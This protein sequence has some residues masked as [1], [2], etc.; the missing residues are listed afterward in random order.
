M[1]A[2]TRML[3]AARLGAIVLAFL[4]AG[5][6]SAAVSVSPS[7]LFIPE[8]QQ[9]VVTITYRFTGLVS[10]L[11]GAYSGPLSSPVGEF[12]TGRGILLSVPTTV[13]A[14]IQGGA[15]VVTETLTLPA[16]LLDAVRRQG[17]VS[18][19]YDRTFTDTPSNPFIVNTASTAVNIGSEASASFAIKRIELYFDNR[20]G[21]ITVGRNRKGLKAYADI[22]FVGSG[23]LSGFWEV[24]GRRILDVNRH[25]SFGTSVMLSTPDV[26]DLPTFD[27]GV[28]VVR[29]VVLNPPLPISLP[30]ALYFVTP[31]EDTV[32]QVRIAIAAPPAGEGGSGIRTFAWERPRGID[33]FLVEFSETADGKPIFSAF[34]KENRYTLP[35]SGIEG[36]FTSG[37]RYFWRVKG[38]DG[39][40][41]QVGASVPAEFIF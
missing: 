36:V 31:S 1:N 2:V 9:S 34:A 38:Y 29:F 40:E 41:N 32:R 23:L 17:A 13:T 39:H 5:S 27:T 7:P 21:E 8:G 16:S 22:R 12:R 30:Q 28:H 26:P 14:T 6:A 4:Y 18:L 11:G 10:R 37:K 35:S 3:H 33:L 19:T 20:R 25:L 24:D 15:G